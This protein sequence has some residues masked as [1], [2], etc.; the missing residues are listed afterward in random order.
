MSPQP[1]I[2]PTPEEY[3]ALIGVAVTPDET[4]T[5]LVAAP[6]LPAAAPCCLSDSCYRVA[7]I[8]LRVRYD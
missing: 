5:P 7:P 1:K 2:H 6:H 4:D 3:L 8:P